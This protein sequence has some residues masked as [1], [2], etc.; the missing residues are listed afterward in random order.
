MRQVSSRTALLTIISCKV[1]L[2]SVTVMTE[3]MSATLQDMLA[4]GIWWLVNNLEVNNWLIYLMY[5]Y[6]ETLHWILH[7]SS[8]VS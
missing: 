4:G 5:F 8:L 7:S 3:E 6:L 1:A 2:Q